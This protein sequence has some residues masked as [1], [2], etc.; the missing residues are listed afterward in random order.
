MKK[1][2]ISP[3]ALVALVDALS[4]IYWYKNDLRKYLEGCMS[5]KVLLATLDWTLPKR[6]IVSALISRMNSR[7]DLYEDDLLQLIYCT[8]SFSDFSHLRKCEDYDKLAKDAKACVRRLK[9]LS[10]GF[11]ENQEAK[12]HRERQKKAYEVSIKE[13]EA[14][15]KRLTQLKEQ[16]YELIRMEN[17]QARGYAFEK[18]LNEIFALFD[19]DPRKSFKIVGQQI[20]GSFTHEG[21]DYLVEAKWQNEPSDREELFTLDGKVGTTLKNTLGLFVAYNGFTEAAI[22]LKTQSRSLILMDGMD[23][24]QVIDGKIRLNE[25]LV[26]KRRHAAQT[27]EA[28][29]RVP[30]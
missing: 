27:G 4:A 12:E 15:D 3:E 8:S 20:D 26:A 9:G 11:F 23:L 10:A 21:T 19:L 16:F 6:E 25:L 14:F 24:I 5:N 17:S 22:D 29:Y 18:F 13:R 1:K 30:Y 2:I 7:L 28:M